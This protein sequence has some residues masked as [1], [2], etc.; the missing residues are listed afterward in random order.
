MTN[1]PQLTTLLPNAVL[2][3]LERLR[4]A[5]RTRRANRSRGEHFTGKGGT[6]TE[7]CDFRDYSPGDDTRFVDWNIFARLRRP[8]LRQFHQ[9]QERHVVLLVD[10]SA[11][12]RFEQKLT[13]ARQLAAA[14]GMMGLLGHERVSV[15]ASH[16]AA[17]AP[18]RLLPCRGR[19][20][21]R[22]LFAFIEGIDGGGDA[23]LE[24]AVESLLKY[25]TGRGVCVILSDF[26]T[27]GDLKRSFNMLYAT[28]LE[29]Y[30]IQILSPHEI[31][32]ELT[33]DLRLVDEETQDTLDVSSASELLGLYQEYRLGLASELALLCQR[34]AGRFVSVSSAE[35]ADAVLL[36]PLR[37]QGWIA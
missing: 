13:L 4:L 27:F 5:T 24:Q 16:L 32:P 23:P 3:R 7:F 12:M 31:A 2:D 8:Y 18:Q 36:G 17:E 6:S 35:A 22:R 21:L 1:R 14:F 20:S 30:G 10:A 25:H 26:L 28:G 29:P 33:G 19:V 37:R 9:E 15:Y 34:R 11:S